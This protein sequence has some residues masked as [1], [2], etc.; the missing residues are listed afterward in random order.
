MRVPCLHFVRCCKSLQHFS[1]QLIA[2]VSTELI[3]TLIQGRR[4]QSKAEW[5]LGIQAFWLF[6]SLNMHLQITTTLCLSFGFPGA[7]ETPW[8]AVPP[9][10]EEAQRV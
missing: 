6:V 4:S 5:L 1:V 7:L 9:T 10:E 2:P 8:W 3:V